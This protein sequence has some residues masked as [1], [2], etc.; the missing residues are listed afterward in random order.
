MF[1]GE[2]TVEL[3]GSFGVG[4]RFKGLLGIDI[5]LGCI[6]SRAT[7]SSGVGF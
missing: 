6:K 4:S 5:H 1:I 2:G 7:P 3:R